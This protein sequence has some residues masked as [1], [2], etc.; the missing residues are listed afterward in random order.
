VTSIAKA[1]SA[2]GVQYVCDIDPVTG[3]ASFPIVSDSCSGALLLPSQSCAVAVKFVRHTTVNPDFFIELNTLQCTASTT[4]NCEI[5]AG[6]FPVEIKANPISPLTMTP[7]AGLDFGIQAKG[8]ISLKPLT[9]TLFNDPQYPDA[10]NPNPQTVNFSAI[11]AKGDYVE[12]DDCFGKSLAPGSSCAISI[13]FNPQVIGFD[14][15]NITIAL[16]NGQVQTI[17]LRGFGQ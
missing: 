1:P 14:Q 5:D 16:T 17:F 4:S 7:G 3:Q 12:T 8:Q 9:V 15:G 6:R 10:N 2:I 13:L 11:I